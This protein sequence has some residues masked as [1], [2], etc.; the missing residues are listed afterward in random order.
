MDIEAADNVFAVVVVFVIN[1]V[2]VEDTYS[3]L[4]NAKLI[5]FVVFG[6]DKL[7]ANLDTD[8]TTQ[9]ADACDAAFIA[10]KLLRDN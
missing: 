10:C 5:A 7:A 9:G 1:A 4:D 2:A 3:I 8:V 6:F